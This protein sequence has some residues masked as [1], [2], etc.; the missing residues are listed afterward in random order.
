MTVA[1]LP[2]RNAFLERYTHL[3]SIL[4]FLA[5]LF[6]I[7]QWAVLN[8][9]ITTQHTAADHLVTIAFHGVGNAHVP[10]TA[11][12]FFAGALAP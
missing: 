12:V 6:V 1:E 4:A 7:S 9:M 8:H 2:L 11:L 10:G 5:L 3:S